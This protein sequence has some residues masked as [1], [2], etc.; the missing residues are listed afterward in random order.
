M[1]VPPVNI[2]SPDP[3]ILTTENLRREIGTLRELMTIQIECLEDHFKDADLRYKERFEAADLRYQQRYDAS[4]LALNAA[5]V[6]AKEAINA[7]MAAAKEAVSTASISAEKAIAAQNESTGASILKSE[8]SVTKQIDSIQ[9]ALTTS[10]KTLDEKIGVLNGRLDR[11]DGKISV[12]DPAMSAALTSMA[13]AI[14]ALQTGNDQGY[15]R[16]LGR[17]EMIAW[18]AFAIMAA[19]AIVP[20][21]VKLHS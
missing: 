6:A 14:A 11:G 10:N 7:A 16:A 8:L 18:V 9:T 17:G 12:Q 4:V 3:S 1:P 5:S 15:G 19:A 13:N 2:P 20:F 21:L